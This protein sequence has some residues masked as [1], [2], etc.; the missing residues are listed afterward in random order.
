[1]SILDTDAEILRRAGL[2]GEVQSLVEDHRLFIDVND[3]TQIGELEKSIE[4]ESVRKAFSWG[5]MEIIADYRT[6]VEEG[7]E[8]KALNRLARLF[9]VETTMQTGWFT[10]ISG[11]KG[12]SYML[13]LH[14]GDG[15]W[16]NFM[17]CKDFMMLGKSKPSTKHIIRLYG[18]AE[19]GKTPTARKVFY[20]IKNSH[21]EHAI[22]YRDD[23]EVKGL[24]F[25]GNAMVGIDSQGDPTGGQIE[26]LN[27][28]VSMGCQVNFICSR[29]HGHTVSEVD[30]FKH[31][32]IIVPEERK[33]EPNV[34]KQ[35]EVNTKQAEH[36]VDL[37]EEF[38][39]IV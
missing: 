21:P 22:I 9:G 1:M 20:T 6:E 38:A 18:A 15:I 8:K 29:K 31:T 16:Y 2:W 33:Y 7:R 34:L 36:I 27:D 37:I 26:T 28:F 11:D 13:T 3:E 23:D 39:S 25:I 24:F 4:N 35:D 17:V 30:K 19:R 14:A 12:E 5:L 10:H 32:Y